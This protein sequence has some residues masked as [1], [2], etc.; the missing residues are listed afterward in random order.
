MDTDF[1]ADTADG[2]AIVNSTSLK[3]P[4]GDVLDERP[5]KRAAGVAM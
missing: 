1:E 4:G 5:S 3:R 2:P